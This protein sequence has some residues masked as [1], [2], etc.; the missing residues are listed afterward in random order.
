MIQRLR[1]A[2]DQGFGVSDETLGVLRLLFFGLVLAG[3][4]SG[5]LL[6]VDDYPLWLRSPPRGLPRLTMGV[7]SPIVFYAI[8]LGIGAAAVAGFLGVRAKMA[9]ITMALLTMVHHSFVFSFGKIDHD[10][11]WL[12]TAFVLSFSGWGNRFTLAEAMGTSRPRP[13]ES[14]VKNSRAVCILYAFIAVAFFSA[15]LA[16]ARSDWL[17][18]DNQMSRNWV[19]FYENLA[20]P[21]MTEQ[22]LKL[23]SVLWEMADIGTVVLELGL[24]FLLLFPRAIRFAVL[25]LVSFHLAVLL[26][27]GID[28]HIHLYVYVPFLCHP[29][30]GRR[31]GQ[32]WDRSPRTALAICGSAVV[33]FRL[34]SKQILPLIDALETGGYVPNLTLF[35]V[36]LT[37]LWWFSR[38]P[39]VTSHEHEPII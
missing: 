33:A 37:A 34:F 23:P 25:S 7:Q 13:P 27:M 11:L 28:F 31:F 1:Q 3:W 30:A 2:Q 21:P 35:A 20:S 39:E 14:L 6:F 15:G 5:T 19:V 8:D 4:T 12:A 10:F 36:A 38:G 22:A 26:T 17:S 9:G 18:T 29:N 32:W 24:V 16:K